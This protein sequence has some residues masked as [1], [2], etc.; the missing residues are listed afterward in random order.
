MS[1]TPTEQMVMD[2]YD[3]GVGPRKIGAQLG[4]APKSVSR[5]ISMFAERGSDHWQ[6]SV[7]IASAR[8]RD[9]CLALAAKTKSH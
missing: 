8:L 2:L 6:Q 5:I 3:G 7:A 4:L 9:A 1:T